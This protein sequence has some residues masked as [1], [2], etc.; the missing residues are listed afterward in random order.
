M[1]SAP[2]PGFLPPDPRVEEPYRVTPQMAI[3]IA[4]LGFIAI[5]LFAALF[6]RLW[7]LQIISGEQ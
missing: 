5:A 1:S 4:I 6:F 7:S 2:L 3:R